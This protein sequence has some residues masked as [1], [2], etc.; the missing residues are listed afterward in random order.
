MEY[1]RLKNLKIFLNNMHVYLVGHN[2]SYGVYL[3]EPI[4]GLKFNRGL[5]MNAG[6]LEVLKES[7]LMFNGAKNLSSSTKETNSTSSTAISYWDCFVFHDVDM[8][9][10]NNLLQYTCDNQYPIHFAV[11]VSKF[12]YRLNFLFF[13]S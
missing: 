7:S 13:L 3:V 1:L 2:V 5:L 11:A 10:E 9:P 4:D 8:I 6:F 12:D